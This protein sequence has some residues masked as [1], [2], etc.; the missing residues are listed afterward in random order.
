MCAAATDRS[1]LRRRERASRIA[2]LYAV[3]PD[4]GDTADL[5]ARVAA[6]IAGGAA[7]I[8]YRHKAAAEPLRRAQALALRA[9]PATRDALFVVNDDV[10]L[11]A[12]VAADGVHLGEDDADPVVAR[13]LLGEDAIIGVSCYNDFARAE[14][15]AAAGAD[16]VAFGSF[17][18]SSVK[19]AA[20]RAGIELLE[21]GRGLGVPVIAIGG[22]TIDNAPRLI[23]AGADAVAVITALFGA[24]DSAG[25]Q[26]AAR[27]FCSA[28]AGA[29][30]AP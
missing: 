8:Q 19:P 26:A 16:Y 1:R 21:R 18:G 11:A 9:H 27:S 15:M 17:Y 23:R 25:V 7:T 10:A 6:A 24:R 29:R 30:K 28:I 3:T 14:A 20:R 13:A 2:G 22:I 5:V 12:E 4:S